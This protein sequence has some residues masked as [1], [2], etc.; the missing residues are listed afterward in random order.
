MIYL[1][2][3]KH[4]RTGLRYFG[5]TT[6]RNPFKYKGSGTRWK[7]HC[8]KHGWDHVVTEDVWGFDTQEDC[9]NF[10][11]KFSLE[12]NIVDSDEWANLEIEDGVNGKLA[13]TIPKY[14]QRK[15]GPTSE[16]HLAALDKLHESWKGRKH[17]Q[18]TIEKMKGPKTEESR[19]KMSES[20]KKRGL[21]ML[22]CPHCGKIGKG[23]GM[24]RFHFSF[25]K[26]K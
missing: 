17:A 14:K 9:T 21:P 23:S 26:L 13:G 20:A 3:K 24:R 8:D 2:Q 10:A 4:T 22:T 25:C 12:N 19:R 18:S 15:R 1:Y 11:L 5:R 6:S 7:Y 16:R